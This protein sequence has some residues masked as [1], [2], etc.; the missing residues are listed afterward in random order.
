M[1]IYKLLFLAF[2]SCFALSCS[3]DTFEDKAIDDSNDRLV[4]SQ[5]DDSYL[6]VYKGLFSTND[7]LT[8]GSVVVTVSPNNEALAQITLSSGEM[9]ELK[10]SRVKLT[11][12]NTISNLSFSS[13]GLNAKIATLNFSVEGNGAN[14]A[15]SDVNFENQESDILIAKNL[16]R[17]PLNTITGTYMRTAGTG[18]FPTSG[19]TWNIMS[20][21]RDNQTYST[22][23]W[24]G[25]RLYNT[26]DSSNQSGCSDLGNGNDS[27]N[28]NGSATIL[29]YAVTWAGTHIYDNYLP[30]DNVGCSEVS[31]TWSAPSYGGSSGTFV[32]DSDCSTLQVTNDICAN[33]TSISC[34]ESVTSYT[35]GA[36][37]SDAPADC[38][39]ALDMDA[40]PGVWYTFESISGTM[41]FDTYGSDFDTKIAVYTGSCGALVCIAG[42]DD[43]DFDGGVYESEVGILSGGEGETLY[44][45]V[46]GYDADEF[47]EFTLNV[48]CAPFPTCGDT[49][50][51]TGGTTGN[52]SNDEFEVYYIDAGAGNIATM[53]FTQFQLEDFY[54]EM[55]FY[56]TLGGGATIDLSDN[57]VASGGGQNGGFSGTDLSGDSITATGR[58]LTVLF[59]SDISVNDLG[60]QAS[61]SCTGAR[62]AFSQ[63]ELMVT[64]GFTMDVISARGSN[65][66]NTVKKIK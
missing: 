36:T 56:D 9:I 44:I 11:V 8:R 48:T 35:T 57:G 54:D 50:V 15:I 43:A 30:D 55:I 13:E 26:T 39:D 33:A 59:I 5:Y 31:G 38:T 14:P 29:G 3:Q 53:T 21:G 42:N 12:D 25:G 10:S 60:Y 6:G 7:G 18:G 52:Y 23:I 19:R 47:G 64:P 22:Q 58:Y 62:N 61:I 2:L 1:K 63:P 4:S 34:G 37:N 66:R 51:D 28:I 20:V 17:A 45:Y 16:S 41:T 24:Y 65:D 40:G 49:I 46:T 32:S 27:C